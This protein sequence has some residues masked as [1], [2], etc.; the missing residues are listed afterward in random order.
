MALE[1]LSLARKAPFNSYSPSGF[2]VVEFIDTP[3]VCYALPHLYRLACSCIFLQ[4]CSFTPL[5]HHVP[6]YYVILR[7]QVRLSAP[8]NLPVNINTAL[9]Q[10][11]EAPSPSTQ[12][13][14]VQPRPLNCPPGL[15]LVS[16]QVSLPAAEG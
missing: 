7:Q 6:F 13:T 5:Y 15:L 8:T 9:L 1:A 3:L 11:Q 4:L 12:L 2:V 10:Y 14:P 16:S